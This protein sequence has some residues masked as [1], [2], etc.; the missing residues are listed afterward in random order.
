MWQALIM[1]DTAV[2]S[3]SLPSPIIKTCE[4]TPHQGGLP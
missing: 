1:L 4:F 3:F 2:N